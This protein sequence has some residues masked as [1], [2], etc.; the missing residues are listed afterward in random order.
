MDVSFLKCEYRNY[1]S[2]AIGDNKK[3]DWEKVTDQLNK[4]ADWTRQGAEILVKLVQDYGS[5]IL[6]NSF[7]LAIAADIEDGKLEL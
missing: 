6:K 4:D 5:F 1:I 2:K 7:A 3:I